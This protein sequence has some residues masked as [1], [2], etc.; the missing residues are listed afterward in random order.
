M[1]RR[2]FVTSMA[3]A[4]ELFSKVYNDFG[5]ALRTFHELTTQGAE[6]YNSYL[7]AALGTDFT[8]PSIVVVGSQ[9]A[10]KSSVIERVGVTPRL[11]WFAS[12]ICFCCGGFCRGG[13]CV[14]P[15]GPC[16]GVTRGQI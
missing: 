11:L 3:S 1:Y 5:D 16:V 12:A 13:L 4:G 9:N 6:N 14:A 7:A 2:S 10:G 15:C 8:P